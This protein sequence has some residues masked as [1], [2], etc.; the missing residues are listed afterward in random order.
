MIVNGR[1]GLDKGLGKYTRSDTTGNSVVDNVICSPNL[2][3]KIN[4]FYIPE[5]LTESD[6]LPLCMSLITDE[7]SNSASRNT[8]SSWRPCY[9]YKWDFHSLENMKRNLMDNI[10]RPYIKGLYDSLADLRCT[11]VVAEA[12]DEYI[13]QAC[14]RACTLKYTRPPGKKRP[15]PWYDEKCKTKRAQA[16]RACHHVVTDS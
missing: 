5:K 16:I 15:S 12:L 7:P 6:H 9:R 13:M 2:F 14:N 11:S 4:E 8:H 3:V 1:I 10:P